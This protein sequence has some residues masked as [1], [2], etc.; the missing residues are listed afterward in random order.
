MD[1]DA[2]Q[3]LG[4]SNSGVPGFENDTIG[5]V[6]FAQ[7]VTVYVVTGEAVFFAHCRFLRPPRHIRMLHGGGEAGNSLAAAPAV[8]LSLTSVVISSVGGSFRLRVFGTI[9]CFAL[10]IPRTELTT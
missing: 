3:L 6:L 7:F 10:L 4:I 9:L 8:M 2:G 1:A 5:T